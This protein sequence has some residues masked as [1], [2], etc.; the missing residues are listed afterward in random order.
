VDVDHFKVVNDSFG[1]ATGD[2]VLRRIGRLM[3]AAFP[4]EATV[5][6]YGGE[7]FIALLPGGSERDAAA[8]AEAFR[9][10]VEAQS[11]RERDLVVTISA[12][13]AEADEGDSR[14]SLLRK[15]DHAL[16]RAKR[17]GR[18]RVAHGSKTAPS[19]G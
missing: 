12:G 11:W 13:V 9:A 7:E 4:R 16:Y 15:A 10:T 14:E 17:E 5:G 8:Y 6:R 19:S 2:D 3:A 18:N 1:H